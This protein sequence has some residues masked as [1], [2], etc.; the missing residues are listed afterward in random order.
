MIDA[1]DN[2][3]KTYDKDKFFADSLDAIIYIDTYKI[4]INSI[5]E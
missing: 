5:T 2:L 3:F 4:E 1:Y